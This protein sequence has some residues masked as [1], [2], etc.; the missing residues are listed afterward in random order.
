MENGQNVLSVF[1]N[2][3]NEYIRQLYTVSCLSFSPEEN[4]FGEFEGASTKNVWTRSLEHWGQWKSVVFPNAKDGHW[5]FSLWVL[6]FYKMF[7]YS[8]NDS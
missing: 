1:G 6:T 7:F 3:E 8:L 2:W 5:R 4:L